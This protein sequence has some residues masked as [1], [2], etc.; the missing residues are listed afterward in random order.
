M[1]WTVVAG[2]RTVLLVVSLRGRG[3]VT[4]WSGAWSPRCRSA[5]IAKVIGPTMLPPG[6]MH[7][8]K[9]VDPLLA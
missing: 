1:V 6:P 4:A 7:D 9:V 5:T 3:V 2:G 8:L